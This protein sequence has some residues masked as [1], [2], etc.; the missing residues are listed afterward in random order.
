[1]RERTQF[2]ESVTNGGRG[3]GTRNCLPDAR[4]Q[5]VIWSEIGKVLERE[6]DG[7]LHCARIAQLEHF[8]ALT[9]VAG[10]AGIVRQRPVPALLGR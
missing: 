1:L 5:C 4:Q 8:A 10:H 6:V 9:V 7:A 3:V 2:V